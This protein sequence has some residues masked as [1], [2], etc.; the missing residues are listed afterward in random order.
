M[1]LSQSFFSQKF[2]IT[3]NDLERYLGEALS[4]GGDYADLYF[5]Y[6]STCSLSLEESI[7]KSA[8]Q[9]V[10]LGVGDLRID[11]SRLKEHVDTYSK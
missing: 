9:G 6:V 3:E 1:G 7:L 5:E 8:T 11:S 4:R 2:G 10:T